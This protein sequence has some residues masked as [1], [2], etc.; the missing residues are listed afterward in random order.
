M[1]AAPP[2]VVA[3]SRMLRLTPARVWEALRRELP[4]EETESREDALLR[5]RHTGT[6]GWLPFGSVEGEY[7]LEPAQGGTLLTYTLKA[8]GIPARLEDFLR[9]RLE[10]YVDA[11]LTSRSIALTAAARAAA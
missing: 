6:Q 7:R 3:A 8:A 5:F 2:L 9:R 11:S 1:N 4:G 10:G